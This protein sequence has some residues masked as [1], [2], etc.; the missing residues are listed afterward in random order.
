MKK[1]PDGGLTWSE[2]LGVPESWATSLE[3]PT[4][5]RLEAT[6]R[7]RSRELHYYDHPMFGVLVKVTP[8]GVQEQPE[9]A[10]DPTTA[11]ADEGAQPQ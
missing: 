8:Y 11:P 4:L 6:R 9:P 3:V 7:M 2:R 5:F 1:S 10:G